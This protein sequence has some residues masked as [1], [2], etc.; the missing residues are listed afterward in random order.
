[1]LEFRASSII[2]FSVN[3]KNT[4][5]VAGDYVPQVYLLGRVASIVR[6]VKQLV[7]FHRVHLL[8]GE[9]TTVD[10]ALDVS[11]YLVVLDREYNWIVEP[12]EYTFALLENGGSSAD[13]S[14]NLTINC[15]H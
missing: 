6:P 3:V 15:V 1:M 14:T 4:G 7:A 13:T 12:G 11:R 10:M 9:A 5:P 8:P 2:T